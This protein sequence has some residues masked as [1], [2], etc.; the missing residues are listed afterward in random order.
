[1]KYSS[2]CSS[3]KHFLEKIF[4][5]LALG[6]FFFFVRLIYPFHKITFT[7]TMQLG[8]IA[9]FAKCGGNVFFVQ[10]K[11]CIHKKVGVIGRYQRN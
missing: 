7:I 2:G 10:L 11:P 8:L 9:V 1:M 4:L 3:T 6:I 5:C